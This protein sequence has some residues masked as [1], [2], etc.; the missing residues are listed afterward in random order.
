MWAVDFCITS[1][2]DMRTA[3]VDPWTVLVDFDQLAVEA[4]C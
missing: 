2:V 4:E 1:T 3:G